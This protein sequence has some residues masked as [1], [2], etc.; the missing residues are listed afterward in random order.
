MVLCTYKPI[1]DRRHTLLLRPKLRLDFRD[2]F[3]SVYTIHRLIGAGNVEIEHLLKE[4]NIRNPGYFVF[5]NI[6]MLL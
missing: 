3:Y 1:N 5:A 4:N 2:I 6:S